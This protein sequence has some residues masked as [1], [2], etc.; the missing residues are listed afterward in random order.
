LLIKFSIANNNFKYPLE[1][2]NSVIE[3]KQAQITLNRQILNSL[4]AIPEISESLSKQTE[5]TLD[6]SSKI[7][8]FSASNY[9][10]P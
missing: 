5:V 9:E 2:I 6:S 3:N 10:A 7:S 4:P 1:Q 8:Q